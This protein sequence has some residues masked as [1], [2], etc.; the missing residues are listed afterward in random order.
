[1]YGECKYT[2]HYS[3]VTEKQDG[4]FSGTMNVQTGAFSAIV[5]NT[6]TYDVASDPPRTQRF[7]LGKYRRR[8]RKPG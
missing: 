5:I 8:R 2:D 1:M 7:R 3:N 6:R 4:S